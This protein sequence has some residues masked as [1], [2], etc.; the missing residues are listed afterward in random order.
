[1]ARNDILAYSSSRGGTYEV[2]SFPLGAAQ[3]F[4]EGD[5]VVF[6]GGSLREA[7]NDPADVVGIA[8]VRSIDK[9][10]AVRATGTLIQVTLG[11]SDQLFQTTN[12][13]TGGSGVAVV[14]TQA[15]AIGA[16]AGLITTGGSWFVDTGAGNHIVQIESLLD[17]TGT[18]IANPNVLTTAGDR[19]IFRFI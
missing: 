15:N 12:F 5:P 3:S 6:N 18:D 7:S 19:V 9:D 8:A 1:M 16:T 17:V 4:D 14:P 13:S 11:S 2:Q 10:D